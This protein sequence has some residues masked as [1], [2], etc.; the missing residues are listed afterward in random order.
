[1]RAE[2]ERFAQV[3]EEVR[4]LVTENE[5]FIA[6]HEEQAAKIKLRKK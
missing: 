6:R 5:T 1:M 3:L 4:R 2:K